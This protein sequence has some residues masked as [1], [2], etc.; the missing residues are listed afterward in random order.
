MVGE[1]EKSGLRVAASIL[2]PAWAAPTLPVD[3]VGPWS[4]QTKLQAPALPLRA[5]SSMMH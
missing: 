2:G 4:H 3:M 5:L 1:E